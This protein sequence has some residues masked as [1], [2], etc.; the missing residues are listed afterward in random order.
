MLA[1]LKVC[2]LKNPYIQAHCLKTI[3]LS[4]THNFLVFI[5]LHFIK[6]FFHFTAANTLYSVADLGF[7]IGVFKLYVRA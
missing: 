6:H 3:M 4:D 2:S 5:F 7:S 1:I